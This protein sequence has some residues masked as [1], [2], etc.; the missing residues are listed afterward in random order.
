MYFIYGDEPLY[1]EKKINDIILK[2]NINN[3]INFYDD[4][5]FPDIIDSIVNTSLFNDKELIILNNINF[6]KSQQEQI[7]SFLKQEVNNIVLFVLNCKEKDLDKTNVLISFLLKKANSFSFNKVDEKDLPNKIIELVEE[8]G[9]KINKLSAIYLASKLPNEMLIISSEIDKLLIN[10]QEINEELIDSLVTKY[11]T[12]NIYGFLNALNNKDSLQVFKEYQE[13]INHG[14]EVISLISSISTIL[15]ICSE[16]DV[17][18][19]QK[20][21]LQEISEI[22]GIHNFRIEN[23]N[24]LL[25]KMGIKKINELILSLAELDMDIK[26]GVIEEK[27]GFEKILLDFIK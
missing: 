8:K 9:G 24:K 1:I 6:N 10:D 12:K 25:I 18:K 26:K 2:N 3:C 19:K 13:K 15:I 21:S 27:I 5:S 7:I 16:I 17:L 4:S 22:M 14:E 23:G 20:K 11:Q